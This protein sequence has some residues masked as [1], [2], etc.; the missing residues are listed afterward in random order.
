[1]RRVL[2]LS[3][4]ALGSLAAQPRTGFAGAFT[5][6]LAPCDTL[7]ASPVRLLD[8]LWIGDYR[9]ELRFCSV[10]YVPVSY[11][12]SP[13]VPAVDCTTQPGFGCQVDSMSGA[14]TFYPDTCLSTHYWEFN[15]GI[16][17]VVASAGAIF[18]ATLYGPSGIEKT[19]LIS[20]PSVCDGTTA[21]VPR[22]WGALKATYR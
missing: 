22:T 3:L 21:V 1:M 13:I 7:T 9:G 8:R 12:G 5:E 16:G 17:I 20:A 6:F 18:E 4:L 10:R 14:V 2:G 15:S 19:Q 11:Q